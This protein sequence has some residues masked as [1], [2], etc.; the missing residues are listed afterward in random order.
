MSQQSSDHQTNPRSSVSTTVKNSHNNNTS[1]NSSSELV[2]PVSP[3]QKRLWILDQ[4]NPDDTSYNLLISVKISGFLDTKILTQALNLIV[5][6]H[7][8]LR[9]NIVGNNQQLEQHISR[10]KKADINYHGFD[11]KLFNI[12]NEGCLEHIKEIFKTEANLHFNLEKDA[13]FRFSLI[14]LHSDSNSKPNSDSYV[15]IANIHH[16]VTD[17]WSMS[18]FVKEL[19]Q[20]YDAILKKD[21]SKLNSKVHSFGQ[22]AKTK[23]DYLETSKYQDELAYWLIQLKDSQPLV[24]FNHLKPTH[25]IETSGQRFFFKIDSDLTSRL[26]KLALNQ[27]VTLNMLLMAQYFVLLHRY[28]QQKDISIGSPVAA[29]KT[30]EEFDCIGFF[31]NSIVFRENINAEMTFSNFVKS[32][33]QTSINALKYQDVPFINLVE[34]L[35]PERSSSSNPLY[36]VSFAFQNMKMPENNYG[37]LSFELVNLDF[38]DDEEYAWL[39]NDTGHSLFD[40]TLELIQTHNDNLVA[41]FEFNNQ[42]F[43]KKYIS[44][45]STHFINL[46][47]SV[48]QDPEQRIADIKILSETEKQQQLTQWQSDPVDLKAVAVHHLFEAQT[49]RTPEAIAIRCN[50]Q[51]MDYKTLNGKA[52]QLAHYLIDLGIGRG[53]QIGICLG[54]SFDMIIAVLATIK[55][56]ACYLPMDI[57]YPK[58]RLNFMLEEI[59]SP[60]ILTESI[61]YQTFHNEKILKESSTKSVLSKIFLMDQQFSLCESCSIENPE[62]QTEMNDPFYTIFTSGSTGRPKGASVSHFCE[63]NMLDWYCKTT[64]PMSEVDNVL[65]MS[66]F[67]FDLTQ[68]NIFA[69]L[70]S[71]A[72]LILPEFNEYEPRK[73]T[74]LIQQEK[75]T[76]TTCTPSA[77]NP[78]VEDK[79][80]WHELDSLKYIFFGGEPLK[81]DK[82]KAWQQQS[83]CQLINTFGPTECTDIAAWHHLENL[84]TYKVSNEVNSSLCSLRNV[85]I[86]KPNANVELYILDEN[87]NLLPQGVTGEICIGGSS[88]GLGYINRP[89]LT[90]EKFIPNPFSKEP[91]SI[92]YRTGDLGRYQDDDGNIEHAGRIDFQLKLRGLRIELGEIEFALQQQDEIK[93]ALVV[94]IDEQIVAYLTHSDSH[95]II[96]QKKIKQDL[97]EFLPQF[98][99]PQHFIMLDEFPLT[100][101]GKIDRN[102]LPEFSAK[103][104]NDYIAPKTLLEKT[105]S[106]IWS[107]V[108][109]K[110]KIGIEDNFFDLGGHSLLATQLVSRI[111]SEIKQ[112][113]MLKTIFDNPTISALAL[114]LSQTINEQEEDS[115]TSKLY[116]PIEKVNTKSRLIPLS[117]SQQR[118]WFIQNLDK[119][120]TAYAMPA[121]FK[122]SGALDISALEQSFLKV[123]QRHDVLRVNFIEQNELI[124]QSVGELKTWDLSFHDFSSYET[125]KKDKAIES[126]IDKQF[127]KP[128]DL[129]Q[130]QLLRTQLLKVDS[131]HHILVVSMHHI[132][133]DGWSVNVLMREISQFYESL[134]GSS[135]VNV[136]LDDLPIQYTDYAVWQQRNLTGEYLQ[137][138]LNF[139]KEKLRDT[140]T[141]ELTTDYSRPVKQTFN[142]NSVKYNLSPELTR[143]LK[144]IVHQEDSTLFMTLISA[145]NIL[146]KHYTGQNDICIG[147]PIANRN[148]QE[149]EILI[150]FFVNTIV[151][152][153]KFKPDLTI[154]ELLK[155]IKATTLEAYE[156]QDTPFEKIIDVLDVEHSLS[157]TPLF[158]VMFVL[159]SQQTETLKLN[160]VDVEF[161][162]YNNKTAKFDLTFN[163]EEVQG[164]LEINLEYNCDLYKKETIQQ[165]LKHYEAA[166]KAMTYDLEQN[167]DKISLLSLMEKKQILFDFNQAHFVNHSNSCLHH[168]FEQ[169]AIQNPEQRAVVYDNE[170]ITYK[171]LNQ[172]ANQLAHFL[173]DEILVNKS[174]EEKQFVGIFI[175]RS[176]D[177]VVAILAALKAG[178]AYVPM[179]PSY[180][181]E[182]IQYMI[183]DSQ[184]SIILTKQKLNNRLT[185]LSSSNHNALDIFCLDSQFEVVNNYPSENVLLDITSDRL[186]YMIYTSGSTGQPKGVLC[187]HK[188]LVNLINDYNHK[189]PINP[190][191]HCSAWS[192]FSFD[193][194]VYELFT[195]L[196]SGGILHILSE[197]IRSDGLKVIKYLNDYQINHCFF[198]AIYLQQFSQWLRENPGQSSLKRMMTGVESIDESLLIDIQAQVNDLQIINSYGPTEATIICL[199]YLIDTDKSPEHNLALGSGMSLGAAPIGTPIENTQIYILDQYQNPVPIGVNGEIYVGGEGVTNGY[200]QNESLTNE[201]FVANVFAPNKS[202]KLYR[203][204]DMARFLSNGNVQFVGRADNQIK[205]RGYR[206]ELGEIENRLKTLPFILESVV[207]VFEEE[208]NKQLIAYVSIDHELIESNGINRDTSFY[209]EKLSGLLP[210]YMV[211]GV[212]IELDKLPLL[213]NGKLDKKSLPDASNFIAEIREK[214]YKAPSTPE[215]ETMVSIWSDILLSNSDASK[216]IGVNDNFFELGGHSLIATQ[217]ITRINNTFNCNLQIMQLFEAPHISQLVKLM[218]SDNLSI[219]QN[220]T[221]K[222]KIPRRNK[223]LNQLTFSQERFWFLDKYEPG[224]TAYNIPMALNIIGNVNIDYLEESFQTIIA[225]H[226]SLRTNFIEDSSGKLLQKIHESIYWKLNISDLQ[227]HKEWEQDEFISTLTRQM[228]DMSFDL[229]KDQLFKATL[230]LKNDSESLLLL[231]IHHII[232]D[233]WSMGVILKEVDSLYRF[234]SNER[235]TESKMVAPLPELAIQYADF[236]SYQ[237]DIFEQGGMEHQFSYWQEKLQDVPVLELPIDKLRPSVQTFNGAHIDCSLTRT[238][239]EKIN[240]LCQKYQVSPF[241]FFLTTL[242]VLLFRY[243]QQDDICIGTPIAGRNIEETEE[244]IG[245]FVNTLALR[246]K[247]TEEL[248]FNEL[249]N[250]VKKTT[251]EAYEHQDAPFDQIVEKLQLSRNL[252]TTPV[253]QVMLSMQSSLIDELQFSGLQIQPLTIDNPTSKFDLLL[254]VNERDGQY[255]LSYEYNTDLFHAETIKKMEVHFNSLIDLAC[256]SL[257]NHSEIK[258]T[259]MVFLGQNEIDQ[260]LINWQSQPKKLVYSSVHEMFEIQVERT[261]ENTAIR[262]NNQ[263]LDYQ[264]LNAKANQLA[265][266]LSAKGIKQKDQVGICLGRSFDMIIAVLAVIKTGACYMPMDIT[267]PEQRLKYMLAEVK[268]P[269][270]ITDSLMQSNLLFDT[271]KTFVMDQQWTDVELM[272]TKNLNAP[273]HQ[274][275]PFYT[276]FTSGSTGRPKGASVSHLCEINMLDWYTKTDYP[277]MCNDKVLVMSAFGFDL[278][279]KNIFA[280]LT[281]GATLVLPEFNEYD[282]RLLTRLIKQEQVTWTT[283]TPSALNPLVDDS[284]HWHELES[285]KYVFF[286]GEPLKIDK[287]KDWQLQSQCQ[288]VNTYGPTECTD[289]AA[290]HKLEHLSQYEDINIPIG[291]PNANVKLYILDQNLNL[292]PSGMTG[293]I[294]IGGSSVG[295]GY[296]TQPELTKEKFIQNPFSDDPD[297]IIY[298]TGDLGRYQDDKGNIE[299]MGRIDFQLKLRGLRIELGEI[300]HALQQYNGINE[301]LAVVIDGQ[302]IAYLTSGTS[303][304]E[305]ELKKS[306]AEFL[307]QYMIPVHY[308]HLSEFPLTQ[309]G[310]IDRQALPEFI[311]QTN[312]DYIAPVSEIDHQLVKI[313]NDVLFK[314]K[315]TNKIGVSDDFFSLGGNSLQASQIIAQIRTFYQVE[316]PVKTLFMEPTIAALS[317]LIQKEIDS[318]QTSEE[319]VIQRIITDDSEDKLLYEISSENEMFDTDETEEFEI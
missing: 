184:A 279:Q 34:A 86:G 79:F 299:H 56:G 159:Q 156:F 33:K 206:I 117:F 35:N 62:S 83:Q 260:Q 61:M 258:L 168:L 103:V 94:V 303:I 153:Q 147:S 58:E 250:Q 84:D 28:T 108:L 309:H 290:Y 111:M 199:A 210:D 10:Y 300:E 12:N 211:P 76:W 274:N 189:K 157:H 217:I 150:G 24:E 129:S 137:K 237:R 106:N 287:M 163:V 267:Y 177:M 95:I 222:N 170:H 169:W 160:D 216:T 317:L 207:S 173:L 200:W 293:E 134:S 221:K 231:N 214:N 280:P 185:C 302:I 133:S 102:A 115:E 178:T 266:F 288:L 97:L 114:N 306:L 255:H 223:S 55:T 307:P 51:S 301:S 113:L 57:T 164:A 77:L 145:L 143:S 13:L 281:S 74:Q 314:E 312:N 190:G 144:K 195:A 187:H 88:V 305:V 73:L 284:K 233:G 67:G 146:L 175:D 235:T 261:P 276:I 48:C 91:S 125:E 186:A 17:G 40:L 41:T 70:V 242:N 219:S 22:M 127:N 243:T 272:P 107:E 14:K 167:V 273:S 192:T 249:L 126:V 203:T 171:E 45:L 264:T 44:R 6:K 238:S 297:D 9:A 239:S 43:D 96:D 101:H 254:D 81:I 213:P 149:T 209:R 253:F 11:D 64:Y 30:K 50:G 5:H 263:S 49:Q 38:Y 100:D 194:S 232:S 277:M 265:H 105:L 141:L 26:K 252:S 308:V 225:R 18:N 116:L 60:L 158:Q 247:L 93:E 99:V 128:F 269:L 294:C 90:K 174:I 80:Y 296:I 20:S 71:G 182:R 82:M 248:N 39:E 4:L 313:W 139:W 8:S 285:L 165:L 32:V 54:R 227:I 72:T 241:M 226:E 87:Q 198:P 202:K 246:N 155:E 234:F 218:S 1:R 16:I 275:D 316:V 289:I 31:V 89:E 138:G 151:L 142:G 183:K 25:N 110:E 311:A 119:K 162:P 208:N 47:E 53:D 69:P 205:L 251:L 180:P 188:G 315:E 270:L 46:L 123:V 122:L 292:L 259:D 15:F 244:M 191:D 23:I 166:L 85:P 130:D 21:S 179:D 2:Y 268:S 148:R 304:N 27:G 52:N 75:V 283:C 42:M 154:K 282:P 121:T 298:R 240:T 136:E 66:A 68:K 224:N 197:S 132:I 245:L 257:E 63:I 295:L 98:M 120:S 181:D 278:T 310:K 228:I 152:R 118:L 318:G 65:V 124:Y 135:N 212:F 172:R 37:D 256:V 92:I 140:V 220:Y 201:K 109:G 7:E 161:I 230:V 193:A 176:I 112:P 131:T 236:A 36:N 104:V 271:D 286:G 319:E 204:G 262:F 19:G 29:R 3:A 291:Q 78:L 196:A 229:E 59:N 215:E